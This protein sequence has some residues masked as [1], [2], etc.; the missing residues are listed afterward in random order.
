[1]SHG[2][3]IEGSVKPPEVSL[4]GPLGPLARLIGWI[5]RFVMGLGM[6]ALLTAACILTTGV[7][8]RYFLHVPT[9]WQDEMAVFLLVGATFLC[10]GFVQS[11]RG[12]IG[13]EALTGLLPPAVNRVRLV[14]VD[15][16]SF[17]FCS[18]FAWK[19]V[20]LC[21]EA[22]HEGQ[23]TSSTWAPPLAIPYGLMAAGMVLLSLQ[24]LLQVLNGFL[25]KEASL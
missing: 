24:L 6:L 12:H 14:L 21:L 2:F 22:L 10:G 4:S 11:H 16:A 20:T 7:F 1:M 23:T 19:S 5:N 13:I 3:E 8:L 15:M 9:D 18:F 25:K 17:L